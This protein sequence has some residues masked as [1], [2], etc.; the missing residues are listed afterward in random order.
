LPAAYGLAGHA[1]HFV[2]VCVCLGTYALLRLEKQRSCSWAAISGFAFGCAIL[3]KQHAAIF[4]AAALIWLLCRRLGKRG[5][6]IYTVSTFAITTAIPLLVTAGGLVWAGVWDRFNLWTIQYAREYVSIFPLQAFPHQ[7]AAGFGAILSGGVWVWL[8][9]LMGALLVFFRTPYQRAACFGTGLLLAGLAATVPGF[10]FRG[11]YFLMVMPGIALLNAALLLALA[12]QIKGSAQVQMLKLIPACLF[13]VV[14]G[15]LVARNSILWYLLTPAQACRELYSYNAFPESPEIARY[16]TTHTNPDDT[17]A[18]LGSEPQIFFLAG[19][20]SASGYLYIYP[21]T[22]PQPLAAT[23]RAEFFSEIETARPRY[24]VYF[25]QL[26]SWRSITA[27]GQTQ[28]VIE[29]INAWWRAYSAQFYQK[30]GVVDMVQDQPS[31]FFWDEQL[32]NR[33]N[34]LPSGISIFRRKQ[35]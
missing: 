24:V 25:N 17:V 14:T 34:T 13:L 33:T 31:R 1:T 21:L 4:A 32:A 23:M 19:R 2:V 20:H 9:G 22:E 10:Y 28:Q 30:V 7:F 5:N 6:V 27:L 11:H 3:M 8:F 15:D 26:S 35:D 12:N 16:I 29:S 18:V